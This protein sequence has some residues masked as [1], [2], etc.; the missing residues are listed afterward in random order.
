V[1]ELEADKRNEVPLNPIRVLLADDH[2]LVRAGFRALLEKIQGV[3]VLAEAGT[4]REALEL[5]AQFKP[6][7][8]LLDIAMPELSGLDVLH[9]TVTQFPSVKVIV[10]SI[11]ETEEYALHALRS[12]AAGFLPKTAASVE[13]ELA[14]K[15]VTRG[16][17]YL[18]PQISKPSPAKHSTPGVRQLITELTPRQREVLELIA[19]GLS[20]KDIARALK[21]SSKTV[22]THRAQLMERLKIYDVAGLV[23][24]A[25]RTGLVRID[26]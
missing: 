9:R 1:K 10:L 22:E 11:H 17:R 21:I 12:G 4:G 5:I 15:T 23:R 13:L 3:E 6:D 14:L 25:I 18:S 2:A 20:T 24:Y 19:R 7:V 16:G 26:E 8:V